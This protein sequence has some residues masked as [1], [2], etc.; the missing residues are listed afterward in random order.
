MVQLIVQLVKM[1]PPGF[2]PR[3]AALEAAV[4]PL[5]P[6]PLILDPLDPCVV[7]AEN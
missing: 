7:V 2:E 3:L 1:G 4:L 5:Q 6:R